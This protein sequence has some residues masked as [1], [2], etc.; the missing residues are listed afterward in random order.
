M[1]VAGHRPAGELTAA[2]LLFLLGVNNARILLAEPEQF[3]WV[4]QPT[5]LLRLPNLTAPRDSAPLI[6][7]SLWFDRVLQPVRAEQVAEPRCPELPVE[8]GAQ[9]LWPFKA[10]RK[11]GTTSRHHFQLT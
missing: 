6:E 7:R 5:T 9:V 1:P 10:F 8:N 4:L 2:P 11:S 3:D